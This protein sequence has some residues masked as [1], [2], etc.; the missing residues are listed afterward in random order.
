MKV[1]RDVDSPLI[2]AS[3]CSKFFRETFNHWGPFPR[4]SV[5]ILVTGEAYWFYILPF[6]LHGRALVLKFFLV[7]QRCW[8]VCSANNF[9]GHSSMAQTMTDSSPY[10]ESRGTGGKQT[11]YRSQPSL[12]LFKGSPMVWW[13]NALPM[14]VSVCSTN[15]AEPCVTNF[16]FPLFSSACN[17]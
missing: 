3:L 16:C 5:S 4:T 10:V 12:T 8:V 2:F 17:F 7:F 14:D 9:H 13:I 15:K 6:P 1:L 11:P